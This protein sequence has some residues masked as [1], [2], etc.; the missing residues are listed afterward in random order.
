MQIVRNFGHVIG[1]ALLIA[2]TTIGVGILAM[3]IAT[4]QGGFLPALI[5]FVLCWIFMLFTGLLLL[6]VCYWMP[7]DSNLITMTDKLLGPVGR[8][9]CWLVY[10]FLFI[11]VLTAHV[12]SGGH[13]VN[14]ITSGAISIP[15]AMVLYVIAFAPIVY[16]GAHSVDRLNLCL[17]AGL[18]ISYFG[19]LAFAFPHVDFDLLAHRN[20]SKAWAALPVLFTAFTYQVIVPT[21]VTYMDRNFK[22]VRLTI[23]IGSAIPLVIYLLWEFAILGVVSPFGDTGLI[24]AG[25]LGQTAIFPLRYVV[26]SSALFSFGKWFSFFTMTVSHIALSLAFLDFL[27]DGLGI[28]KTGWRKILLL[29]MIFIPPLIISL[30]YPSIFITAL[31]YAGGISIAILFGLFPPLMAWIGRYIKKYPKAPHQVF[32]GKILLGI[33]ISIIS[34]ELLYE[35]IFQYI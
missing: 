32:G 34:I 1:G 18:G 33:L 28:K 4:A 19:L 25:E 20:W 2:G 27:A 26:N 30:T 12:A 6:E 15:L 3:P 17:M 16:L 35:F 29:L 7:D 22:K 5:I 21:L 11:I 23:I 31:R 13:I 24:R 14:E 10:L 8:W 9:T